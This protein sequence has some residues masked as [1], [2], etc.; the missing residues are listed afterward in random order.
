MRALLRANKTTQEN[1]L[2]HS[3]SRQISNPLIDLSK[4]SAVERSPTSK[5]KQPL[6][7]V[8]ESL[9][10]EE[11]FAAVRVGDVDRVTSLLEME[12]SEDDGEDGDGD[13]NVRLRLV[14]AEEMQAMSGRTA[15]ALAAAQGHVGVVETLLRHGAT[16]DK[17]GTRGGNKAA[18]FF[19][20][21]H[22]HE[23]TVALL[24]QHGADTELDSTAEGEE[25]W[26]PLMA[27]AAAGN[28]PI[29]NLLVKHGARTDTVDMEGRT[30]ID[31]CPDAA[32]KEHLRL[33]DEQRRQQQA[34][35][36]EIQQK[37]WQQQ[38]EEELAAAARQ[39]A[40]VAEATKQKAEEE[41][42]AQADD[43]EKA[44][45]LF[46]SVAIAEEALMSS[47]RVHGQGI[48]GDDNDVAFHPQ[49]FDDDPSQGLRQSQKQ[50]QRPSHAE[51]DAQEQ[52]LG[53]SGRSWDAGSSLFHMSGD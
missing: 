6:H 14:D 37:L 43:E 15:L 12:M 33:I 10:L 17:C 25:G 28:L 5:R 51:A 4:R 50:R 40:I 19:A 36:W 41:A 42:K 13:G 11:Y 52:G 30:A 31:L 48:S 3:M 53:V 2:Q 39:A 46:K 8:A 16:I 22:E 27:A 1:A 47:M 9:A 18:L 20:A 21:T 7:T 44:R 34:E 45:A 32:T 24:L 35:Q 23:A 38:Q 26:T 29:V 49:Q